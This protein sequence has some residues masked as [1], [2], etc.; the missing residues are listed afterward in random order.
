[1]MEE[2]R[3]GRYLALDIGGTLTK[4]CFLWSLELDP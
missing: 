2:H 4:V 3:L 1:M